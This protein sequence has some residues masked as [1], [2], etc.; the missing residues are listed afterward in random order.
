MFSCV[1]VMLLYYFRI[2]YSHIIGAKGSTLKKLESETRATIEIP[3]KGKDGN[4]GTVIVLHIATLL[5]KN[6]N[7]L[8]F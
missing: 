4:I 2:F 5:R 3:K 6:I 7:S 8:G 1:P